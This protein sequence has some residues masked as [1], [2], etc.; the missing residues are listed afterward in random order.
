MSIIQEVL[1]SL[2]VHSRH[3]RRLRGLTTL[4]YGHVNPYGRFELD[5]HERLPLRD[6]LKRLP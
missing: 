5:I 1:S 3:L 2:V 6:A 4:I